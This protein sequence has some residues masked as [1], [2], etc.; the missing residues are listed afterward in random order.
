MSKQDPRA[1]RTKQ[2]IKDATLNL[3]RKGVGIHQ[4]TV[5]QVTKEASLNRTTFYLHYLDIYDLTDALADELSTNIQQKIEP[6]IETNPL[7][8]EEQLVH[9]LQFLKNER[10]Q[11]LLLFQTEKLEALLHELFLKLITIRRERSKKLTKNALIEADIKA[12]S[13]VGIIMWWFKHGQHHEATY[14]ARQIQFM[15][16]K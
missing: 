6:L 12:A 2:M 5:Q 4:L 14:I 1:I 15:Y 11:L 7:N 8:K 9:L 3:L 13:L 16:K 10:E